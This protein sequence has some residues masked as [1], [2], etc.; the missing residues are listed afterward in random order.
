[1]LPAAIECS[2]L[3][4]NHL[5]NSFTKTTAQDRWSASIYSITGILHSTRHF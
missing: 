5:S 4:Y 2:L 3:L 1:M